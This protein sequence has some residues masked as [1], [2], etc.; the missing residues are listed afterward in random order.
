[1]RS[2]CHLGSVVNNNH[3]EEFCAVC[4]SAPA[5]AG[6]EPSSSS[7][8]WLTWCTQRRLWTSSGSC[9][10]YESRDRSSFRRMWVERVIG[11]CMLLEKEQVLEVIHVL[12]TG[13]CCSCSTPSSIRLCWSTSC[14]ETRSWTFLLW[15]VTWTNFTTPVRRW[16]AL[17]WRKSLRWGD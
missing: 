14:T 15:R 5:W 8:P 13:L 9:H 4:L 16:T 10:E 1:M 12:N 2:C 6:Q 3:S 7:M 17:G 11:F